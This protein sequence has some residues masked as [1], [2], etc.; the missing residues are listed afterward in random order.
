MVVEESTAQGTTA[1]A[2][3]AHSG[4]GQTGKVMSGWNTHFTGN[5]LAE[6]G[7]SLNFIHPKVQN[8]IKVVE[9]VKAE[10]DKES[11]QRKQDITLYV[12]GA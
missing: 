9:L 2:K 8:G 3:Q 12:I 5:K 7:M 1:Y 6:K 10:V 11:E 4:G